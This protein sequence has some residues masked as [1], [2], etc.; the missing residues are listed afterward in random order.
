MKHPVILPK[1]CLTV[2]RI[3][4]WYHAMAQHPGRTGTLGELRSRGYWLING[5][6]Q[7]K[8]VVYKCVPCRQLRGQ[9]AT[10]KMSDLPASRLADV[11]P[12][13]YC[14]VDMFGPFITKEG[15]KEIKRYGMIFTCFS[16]RG[17]HLENERSRHRLVHPQS[18][19]IRGSS[20]AGALH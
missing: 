9:P 2:R 3:I 17:V 16:C 7:V 14:G 13:T 18:P 11:P 20:R 4:E 5:N 19:E 1:K 8:S 12:F 6:A 15:R 10:Q